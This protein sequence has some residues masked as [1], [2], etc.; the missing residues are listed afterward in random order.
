MEYFKAK[1]GEVYAYDPETQQ[2]LI[3]E[4]VANGWENITG[5]WPLPSEPPT[6]DQ[7]KQTASYLLSQTDWTA[8]DDIGNPLKSNPYLENQSE[9]LA[10]RNAVR[11]YAVYPV[12]GDISWPKVPKAVWNKV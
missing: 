8:P 12:A 10:Y 11:Q 3:D 7:N 4:A 2:D 1:N 6:A 9:F 5:S